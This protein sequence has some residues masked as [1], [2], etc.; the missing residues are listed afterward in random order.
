MR[1]LAAVL[2]VLLVLATGLAV[3]ADF[4]IDRS[5]LKS[6]VIAAVK[7]QTGRD[8]TMARF[9]V[10]FLPWPSVSAHEVAFSDIGGESNT[11]M[12]QARDIRAS[13]ALVPLL[14]REIR[15]ENLTLQR[16]AVMLHRD[17]AGQA[18][19]DFHAQSEEKATA[20]A[21]SSHPAA[22]WSLRIGSAKLDRMAF[23]LDDRFAHHGGSVSID[24]AEFDGLASSAPY[25]DIHGTRGETPFRVNGHIGPLSLFQGANPPWALSLGA[26]LGKE[27]KQQDWLNFDGQVSDMRHMRGF[28]GVLRGE[29]ASLKDVE[30]LFPNANLPAVTGF[31]GEIGIFDAD[32]QGDNRKLD[33]SRLGVNHLHLH[34]DSA[35]SWHGVSAS[36]LHADAETLSSALTVTARLQGAMP[37]LAMQGVFGTLAQAGTSWQTAF[38]TPLAVSVDLREAARLGKAEGLHGHLSGMIGA[39]QSTLSLDGGADTLPLRQSAL[40]EVTLKGGFER[41]GSGKILV[42]A[43]TLNSHEAAA[44]LDATAQNAAQPEIEG[45]LH[46]QHLDLDALAALWA[47]P[48]ATQTIAPLQ[49]ILPNP[50][51]A[52]TVQKQ[53]SSSGGNAS[54][55][56]GPS[57][58][59]TGQV[60]DTTIPANSGLSWSRLVS[61][62]R[63]ILDVSAETV[64][65]NAADYTGISAQ[66]RLDAGRLTLD[67]VN[68]SGN[69]M[70]LSGRAVYDMSVKPASL[71]LSLTPLLFPATL[72]Q[73]LLAMPN[74]FKGPLMLVGQLEAHGDTREA[75]MASLSGH[76]GLSMVGGAIA[77]GP[78]GPYLGDSARALL[79]RGDLSVR[80]LGLHASFADGRA[81]FDTLGMEAGALS[82]SGHGSYGLVNQTLDLH[83]LPRIGI[84]GTGAST[85]VLVTG[86]LEAPRAQQEANSGG[87]F[88]VTIGGSEPD[89][90]P[91]VL[92]AAREN[93]AGEAAPERKKHNKAAE[94]LHGLG[95]LH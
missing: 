74:F 70:T 5:N 95:L 13:I 43:L 89:A 75:L 46:F 2:I 86:T 35:P 26:T 42:K 12:L 15:L 88:E 24:H 44:V 28:S 7:R 72:A 50:V 36:A 8:L 31:G 23:S 87:R 82:L 61:E 32:P 3:S 10:G 17:E 55:T 93:L 80:C 64:R 19:W 51:S 60:I 77:T 1:R 58:N 66:A 4:L 94:L 69:G 39:A 78:L 59:S 34:L 68:G 65:F 81:Q 30:A 52:L 29:M 14:W 83:L 18:N 11:P 90:C 6:D 37:A 92:E 40:H 41:D 25:L 85:P 9:S 45:K 57:D 62:G 84:A 53:A 47:K 33:L 63:G 73:N 16:G 22:R 48:K 38:E 21:K 67:S 79:P 71:T 76:L 54:Q 49:P 20:P 27:G 56:G 91:S